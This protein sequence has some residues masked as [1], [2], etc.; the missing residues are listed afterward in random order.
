MSSSSSGKFA[1][2][3]L[4]CAFA[5]FIPAAA[6]TAVSPA[7]SIGAD[8][9]HLVHYGDV[10]DVDVIGSVE[11]DWRGTLTPEGYLNGLDTIPEQIFA[12]CRSES[13]IAEDIRKELSSILRNPEVSVRIL[14]RS[15]R[16]VAVLSGAVRLPQRFR[17]K[18]PVYLNELLILSGGITE[19]ASG[20]ISIFRPQNL[21]CA[22]PKTPD[23]NGE[24][25]KTGQS[26]SRTIEV[27][28]AKL[29]SGDKDS[30]PQ[31]LSGDIVT[32]S[33]AFPIYVIG[34]VAEPKQISSRSQVTLSRAIDS[35]G[36]PTKG[37]ELESIQIYRRKDG[38]TQVILADLDKIKTGNADDILLSPYDIVDV[39]QKGGAKR[40]LPPVIRIDQTWNLNS[41][42]LPLR[43]ID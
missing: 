19:T 10:V 39:P 40:R 22:A 6:Q 41:A 3:A 15:N 9:P 20:R 13:E 21:S 8:Q 34:G 30:N 37:A 27:T 16:A 5:A 33:E 7:E 25:L 24:F 23:T 17:I 43:V 28:I 12:L 35:A 14:D 38:K 4:L 11:F 42:G 29:L 2:A 31:I 1:I 18:R 26:G 32:I 36:G